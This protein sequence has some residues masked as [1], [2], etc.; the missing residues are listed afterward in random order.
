MT[1]SAGPNE[2]AFREA[3][4]DFNDRILD[5]VEDREEPVHSFWADDVEFINFE[6][7]PFPGTYRG[8]EGVRRWTRDVFGEFTDTRLDVLEVVEEGDRMAVRMKVTGRGRSSGI[9]GSLEWG[10]L[11]TMRDDQ[12]IR[13]ASDITYERTLE[14]LR[15]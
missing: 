9:G 2:S 3:I 13:A 4:A 12:C 5:Y 7:S 6:P 14:R 15:A 10:S 11:L 8:H 1:A